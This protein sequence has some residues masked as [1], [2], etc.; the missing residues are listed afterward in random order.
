MSHLRTLLVLH[1][2]FTVLLITVN[3]VKMY[4]L[5]SINQEELMHCVHSVAQHCS[6]EV[7][8]LVSVCHSVAIDASHVLPTG[9]CHLATAITIGA[10]IAGII[11]VAILLML[12]LTVAIGTLNGLILYA[13][14]LSANKSILFQFPK[15]QYHISKLSM[16][17]SWL[18]LDI[19]IDTRCFE[20]MDAYTK[21]WLQLAFPIF[22]FLLVGIIIVPLSM[23]V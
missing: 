14:I 11:L 15:C 1:S 16:V 10:V 20:D 22:L 9:L 5:I 12:N 8:E 7:I 4:R 21:M 3:M 23:L 19:G 2:T 18:N 6:V 13:N 17:V